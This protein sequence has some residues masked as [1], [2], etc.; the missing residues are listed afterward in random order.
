MANVKSIIASIENVR[1]GRVCA[2]AD[3]TADEMGN[4][5]LNINV[6]NNHGM[7]AHETLALDVDDEKNMFHAIRSAKRVITDSKGN[8]TATYKLDDVVRRIESV[9]QLRA[10]HATNEIASKLTNEVVR[11]MAETISAGNSYVGSCVRNGSMRGAFAAL[12]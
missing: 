5:W 9:K 1:A 12:V 11:V 2:N 10:A 3:I 8:V 7:T 6:W 4:C